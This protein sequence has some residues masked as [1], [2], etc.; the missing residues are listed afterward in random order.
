MVLAA[1]L[2][3]GSL[4]SRLLLIVLAAP[5]ALLGNILRVTSLLFVAR[6]WGAHAGFIFYHDYSGLGFF[7]IVLALM[8]PIT[9]MLRCNRLRPEVI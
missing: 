5:L 4:G 7:V 6:I 9:R 3:D 8:W 1:Y 2:V